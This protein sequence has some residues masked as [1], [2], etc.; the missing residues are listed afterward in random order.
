VAFSEEQL[1]TILGELNSEE[2]SALN[3]K[4]ELEGWFC[5]ALE[6]LQGD[7]CDHLIISFG[8]GRNKE[9]EFHHRFGP[10]NQLSG[11]NRL[12]VLMTRAREKITLF[13]SVRS[14]DFKVSDNESVNLLR[15][16]LL[17]FE[18]NESSQTLS[19]PH[20][21]T[22][23]READTLIL[24]NVLSHLTDVRELVTLHNVLTSRG[25]D[26]RYN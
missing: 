1:K 25:W 17:Y 21:L 20:E 6:N 14:S 11:R 24:N 22:P 8:Y 23:A 4:I 12:N 13:T 26:V 10:M 5:K 2:V 9:G 15:D 19:F 16:L 7:E 3:D 18:K